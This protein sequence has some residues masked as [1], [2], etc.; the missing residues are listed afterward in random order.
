MTN[1][2]R[3][4]PYP[5]RGSAPKGGYRPKSS[6]SPGV[7]DF[8]PPHGPNLGI[9]SSAVGADDV[10]FVSTGGRPSL[11]T[12]EVLS[13][14]STAGARLLYHGDFD[15]AGVAIANDLVHRLGVL[16]WRMSADDYLAL[17]ARLPLHGT[18]VEAAWDGELSAAMAHRGL[19]VHE[20]A[21]LPQLLHALSG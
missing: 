5:R 21:A 20:E 13:R 11:V 2:P 7:V 17:P 3:N 4:N 6:F 1:Y 10:G 14:L 8:G 16:P 15:W 19:A 12:L 9:D 18:R